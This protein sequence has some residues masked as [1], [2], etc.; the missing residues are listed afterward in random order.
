MASLAAAGDNDGV[1]QLL[2][3]LEPDQLR[4][5]VL[6]MATNQA[7][8]PQHRTHTAAVD[9]D[10]SS[11]SAVCDVAVTQAAQGFGT[12]P[13]AIL[14]ADRHRTVTD[15]RAVAMTAVRRSGLTL[16][17][18]ADHFDKDHTSVIHAVR[19]TEDNPRLL[20]AATSIGE[21]IASR[22]EQGAIEPVSDLPAEGA[23]GGRAA[24]RSAGAVEEQRRPQPTAVPAGGQGI[25]QGI[26]R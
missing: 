18:I 2:A 12:T 16:T 1:H 11:P 24:A 15:A 19:R 13:E 8:S 10:L 9:V 6:T 17:A 25:G 5:L 20:S 3:P 26:G 4:A 23:A 7:A 14:G 21:R 22:Y